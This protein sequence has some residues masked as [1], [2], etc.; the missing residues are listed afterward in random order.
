M[1]KDFSR[2]RIRQY[3][4]DSDGFAVIEE[5]FRVKLE[6]KIMENREKEI[7]KSKKV[8]ELYLMMYLPTD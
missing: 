7:Y 8:S 6:S 4:A 3:C 2:G 5:E 1:D